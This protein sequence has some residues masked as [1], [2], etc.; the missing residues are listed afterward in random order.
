[1]PKL[2]RSVPLSVK[3]AT[4][5]TSLK[6]GTLLALALLTL[7][8]CGHF[9]RTEAQ[10]PEEL[11][12]CFDSLVPEPQKA[13]LSGGDIYQLIAELKVSELNKSE[14]GKR[15]LSWVDSTSLR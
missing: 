12:T 1:M 8:G 10:V 9:G 3:P 2:K 6:L 11:R 14:C 4:L 5:S 13:T 7:S 15:L